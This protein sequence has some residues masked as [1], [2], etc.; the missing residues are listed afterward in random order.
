MKAAFIMW[1]L[2]TDFSCL[3]TK[4]QDLFFSDRFK[5]VRKSAWNIY[6]IIVVFSAQIT[7]S[8]LVT[9]NSDGSSTKTIKYVIYPKTYARTCGK[10]PVDG[11]RKCADSSKQTNINSNE[12]RTSTFSGSVSV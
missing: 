2:K 8:V 5:N 4:I 9:A 11:P 10:Y 3:L 7:H 12:R 6:S 1:K